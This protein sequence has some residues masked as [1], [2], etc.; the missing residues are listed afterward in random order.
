[1]LLSMTAAD[2]AVSK[3]ES[4]YGRP[5]PENAV[6]ESRSRGRKVD[7]RANSARE[8]GTDGHERACAC[9][10]RA[11]VRTAKWI[12]DVLSDADTAD[13]DRVLC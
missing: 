7:A 11:V 8:T 3:Y 1:M 13:R 4:R 10:G 5:L 2:M 6:L 12:R 9:R